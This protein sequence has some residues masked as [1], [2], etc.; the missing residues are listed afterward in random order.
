MTKSHHSGL[1]SLHLG[2]ALALSTGTALA[3]RPKPLPHPI[4]AALTTAIPQSGAR[5]VVAGTWTPLANQ[6]NFL[7]DGAASPILLTDGSVLVQDAG[8]PDWW[9]LTPDATGS[10]V[11]GT[12]TQVASLPAT[13]SPLYHSTA[14]LP[15]GRVIIEGGEYLLSL[16][17]TQL[18]PA[19]TNQGAIYDPVKNTWTMVAPPAGWA[20]IG[21]AQGVVLANGAYMQANCCS[22]EAAILNPQ[23]LTWTATGG[24]SKAD[25]NDEEGWTLLPNGKVL[26][27]DAYVWSYDPLGM[28]SEI[29][30]PRTQLWSSAGST[31]VQLWDS[32]AACGGAAYASQEV[33]PAVLRPNGTVFATGSNG[34]GAA[35]TAI[36]DSRSGQWT[37]GPDF[38]NGLGIGDG[39]AAL[40][41]NGRVLM[42]TSPGVFNFGTSYFEWDGR[43]LIPVP[44]P[45]NAPN[46]SS[47]F[48]NMLV[49]PTGQILL[50]DFYN[51][52]EIYT[53]S[54]Q[55]ESQEYAPVINSVASELKRRRTYTIT[56][57]RFNGVSQGA[58]YGDDAQGATNFPLVRITNKRTGHVAYAR[59]HDH[60]S[61]GVASSRLVSTHFDVPA[62]MESGPSTLQVVVNG[63]ASAGFSVEID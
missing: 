24:T 59:T 55:G 32:A 1:V 58:A 16:D 26:T 20:N 56:G 18:V 62:S 61:M 43:R 35:H 8:F 25:L 51:D 15:D 10:Y 33:G 45:P 46:E 37:A 34:C 11:N 21:D 4:G 7:I 49:L 48:G 2:I 12:W 5:T 57:Y 13:Y 31:G 17:Q 44:S 42:M 3:E 28:N 63:V 54:S 9:R 53:P 47:Y 23:T 22:T 40:E 19:W 50:T 6:P 27:V 39:P 30:D 52:I 29:Y 36:Y 60:S 38:P 41:P 14:V